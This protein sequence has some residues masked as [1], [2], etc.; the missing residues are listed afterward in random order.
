M[1]R[2]IKKVRQ[3]GIRLLATVICI[4]LLFFNIQLV[5]GEGG[6][7]GI[8]LLGVRISVFT[9][10]AGAVEPLRCGLVYCVVEEGTFVLCGRSTEPCCPG[11]KDCGCT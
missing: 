2:R 4:F 10:S 8:G 5:S 3:V 7:T 11:L 6:K 9:P 1:S